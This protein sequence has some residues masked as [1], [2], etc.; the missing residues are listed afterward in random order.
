[1]M[2]FCEIATGAESLAF[3]IIPNGEPN[4]KVPIIS[5]AR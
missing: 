4:A 2:S 3:M 5:N 1:M